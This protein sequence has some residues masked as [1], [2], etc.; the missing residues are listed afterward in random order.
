MYIYL[1]T[2][3]GVLNLI[4]FKSKLG[5]KTNEMPYKYQG[6]VAAFTMGAIIW[7]GLM[8]LLYWTLN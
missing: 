1:I 8:C 5:A 4:N 6:Y 7:G 3:G 2:L